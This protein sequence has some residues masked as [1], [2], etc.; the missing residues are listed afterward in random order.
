VESSD[1]RSVEEAID[2]R[3]RALHQGSRIEWFTV[4]WNTTEFAV[5]VG[6]GML[7]GS[8]AMVAFG[9]DSLIEVAASLVVIRYISR[10]E[11]AGQARRALRL[12]AASFGVPA[13]YL[14]IA[15]TIS[16]LNREV[17]QSS[18]LG[19]AYLALAATMMFILGFRKRR[20]ARFSGS[21]PLGAEARLSF[22]DGL[23][24]T[25]VLLA[26]VLNEL[27]GL[28][29]FDQVAALAVGVTCAL[30]ATSNLRQAS[31]L[32][33]FADSFSP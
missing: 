24:A 29:W 8:L 6:L 12:V 28:W 23:L 19:I 4:A 32:P 2:P 26:L 20:L 1:E 17:A 30:E 5:S 14:L 27:A 10:H 3:H 33:D 22:L 21:S 18:P 31:S 7:A 13:V 9:L 11:S 25:G 15:S 16:L